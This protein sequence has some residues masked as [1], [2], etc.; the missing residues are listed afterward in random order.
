MKVN[1]FTLVEAHNLL[2]SRQQ[3]FWLILDIV[4]IT[5]CNMV[6]LVYRDDDK[7]V[8]V[9]NTSNSSS[10]QTTAHHYLRHFPN[11][12]NVMLC[13]QHHCS[14]HKSKHIICILQ[15]FNMPS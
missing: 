13:R 7:S 9:K 10:K 3:R 1:Q 6:A 15:Y 11:T 8:F 12:G 14:L 2:H 5:V 4:Y